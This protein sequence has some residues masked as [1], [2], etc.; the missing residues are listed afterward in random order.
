MSV[1]VAAAS[2]RCCC[3]LSGEAALG[4][5]IPE[6]TSL[7]RPFLCACRK[8]VLSHIVHTVGYR[9]L[10]AAVSASRLHRVGRGF[11]S[12]SAH[13]RHALWSE[14]EK[15]TDSSGVPFHITPMDSG[16]GGVRMP[17]SG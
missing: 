2:A 5:I 8:V 13:Q 7:V 1:L 9:A 15:E 14:Q 6:S 16:H 11:E 12:L 17:A 10:G 3:P 4:S